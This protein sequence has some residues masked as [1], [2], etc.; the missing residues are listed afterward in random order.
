VD[1]CKDIPKIF[2]TSYL[3]YDFHGVPHGVDACFLVSGLPSMMWNDV[4]VHCCRQRKDVRTMYN[5][6]R[7]DT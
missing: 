1:R 6:V 5:V 2:P 4:F 3:V 7:T